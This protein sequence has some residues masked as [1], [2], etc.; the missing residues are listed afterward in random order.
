[1]NQ[2]NDL[3]QSEHWAELTLASIA[4]HHLAPD[5]QNY[6]IWYEYHRGNDVELT[7]AIDAAIAADGR[8]TE[9]SGAT[10][11]Q[12]FFT[13][14]RVHQAV[15]DTAQNMETAISTILDSISQAGET[16]AHFSETLHKFS[17]VLNQGSI[18]QA[19]I[20][21]LVNQVLSETKTIEQ[22]SSAIQAQLKS[23]TDEIHR[24]QSALDEVQR[25]TSTDP[26]SG[27]A[28]RRHFDLRLAEL[29]KDSAETGEDLSVLV[30]AI[31]QYNS[32]LEKMGSAVGDQVLRLVGSVL[33]DNLKG[34]DLP[35]RFSPEQ[36]VAAL[37]KTRI[38]NALTVGHIFREQMKLKKLVRKS[39]GET[40]GHVTVSIGA[41]QYRPGE[42]S[43]ALLNR[44]ASAH[45]L[46]VRRGGNQIVSEAAIES[47]T[48]AA[49]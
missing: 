2:D 33:N 9:Q 12:R 45:D 1:V 42:P 31:D 13:A 49:S 27:L 15:Q 32:L 19:E 37:P 28:N 10:I 8:F 18:G 14:G 5:P 44:L 24:L 4:E 36:F 16:T 41:A 30:I 11:Y 29:I 34:K 20:G 39:T 38:N 48:A 17:G 40:L 25:E 7:R 21:Q 23:S 47:I 35:A 6:A 46:A 22:H 43:S 26:I 3:E